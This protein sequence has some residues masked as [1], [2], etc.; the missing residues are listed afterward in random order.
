MLRYRSATAWKAR[1]FTCRSYGVA[2]FA[3]RLLHQ[4]LAFRE[5]FGWGLIRR[6]SQRSRVHSFFKKINRG[7]DG[8]HRYA[9]VGQ[10]TVFMVFHHQ[11]VAE[12]IAGLVKAP[13]SSNKSQRTTG[14]SLPMVSF[15]FCV[16]NAPVSSVTFKVAS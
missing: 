16:E 8:I 9:A 5:F 11:L 12:G 14:G 1:P 15:I 10:R 6:F 2:T 3:I 4:S 7:A 13:V